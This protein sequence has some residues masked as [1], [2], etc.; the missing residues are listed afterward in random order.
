MQFLSFLPRRR[1]RVFGN[2]GSRGPSR[3]ASVHGTPIKLKNTLYLLHTGVH[4][5]NHYELPFKPPKFA[6]PLL[7]LRWPCPGLCGFTQLSPPRGAQ[8]K[9]C[10]TIIHVLRFRCTEFTVIV[11]ISWYLPP[12][13]I[14]PGSTV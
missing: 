2:R 12:I 4:S 3:A 1:V 10:T 14:N 5:V 8:Q 11:L 6:P 9:N 13:Y 7:I